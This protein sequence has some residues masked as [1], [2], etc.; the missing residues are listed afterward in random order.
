MIGSKMHS[1]SRWMKCASIGCLM[2]ICSASADEFSFAPGGM[3]L[4]YIPVS[5]VLAQNMPRKL[6]DDGRIVWNPGF[7]VNY[8]NELGLFASGGV[9]RDCYNNWAAYALAGREWIVKPWFRWGLIGG[10]YGRQLPNVVQHPG[11]GSTIIIEDALNSISV[12]FNGHDGPTFGVVPMAGPYVNFSA[13]IVKEKVDLEWMTFG[14]AV[15]FFSTLG[16]RVH[17]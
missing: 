2:S 9:V 8:R 6:T 17:L 16:V 7:F 5:S 14:T 3:T 11:D 13:P 15:L 4:H 10:L 12:V 1:V